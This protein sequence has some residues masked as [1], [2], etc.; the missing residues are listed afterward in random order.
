MLVKEEKE[1]L[2]KEFETHPGDTG[3]SEVQVAILTKRISQLTEH[4]RNHRHD[5]Q[6]QRGL[7]KLVSKRRR[8]LAYLGR[9][10]PERYQELISRLGLRR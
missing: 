7:L 6:S 4:F 9:T 5:Y 3:S 10:H 1:P 8:Q 2:I